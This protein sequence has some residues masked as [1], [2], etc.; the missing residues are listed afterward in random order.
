MDG[1]CPD[2]SLEGKEENSQ[3]PPRLLIDL[4]VETICKCADEHG[5]QVQLEVIKVSCS[6]VNKQI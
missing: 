3:E 4:I 1:D 2:V 6:R 5:D